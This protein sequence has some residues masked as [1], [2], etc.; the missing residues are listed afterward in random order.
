MESHKRMMKL[1]Q[2]RGYLQ[3]AYG[4]NKSRQALYLWKSV[5][6]GT[7]KLAVTKIGGT[8]YTTKEWVDEFVRNTG[9]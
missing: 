2:V 1:A 7:I 5:G 4:I 6:V 9:I 8:Y 3:K